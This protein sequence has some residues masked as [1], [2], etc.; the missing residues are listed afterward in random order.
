M[1]S[2]LGRPPAY[3]AVTGQIN[4]KKITRSV[5]QSSNHGTTHTLHRVTVVVVD[6]VMGVGDAEN[7]KDA[8]RMAAFAANCEILLAVRAL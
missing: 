5:A 3:D 8:E 6:D 1:I 4:G 7:R 2:K